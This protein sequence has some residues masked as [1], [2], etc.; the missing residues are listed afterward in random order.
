MKRAGEMTRRPF[1][2]APFPRR[3]FTWNA[4]PMGKMFHM[5][6]PSRPVAMKH[7]TLNRL[8]V[9]SRHPAR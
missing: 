4:S 3:C 2:D 7:H 8:T 1:F 5:K 6:H 9:A